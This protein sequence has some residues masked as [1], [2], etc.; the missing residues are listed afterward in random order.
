MA[1]DTGREVVITEIECDK[2]IGNA[3]P[4]K[5]RVHKPC[6]MCYNKKAFIMI[7]FIEGVIWYGFVDNQRTI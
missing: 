2:G 1:E 3:G 4:L 7:L 5:I 6:I